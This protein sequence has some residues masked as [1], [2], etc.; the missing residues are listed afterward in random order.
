MSP[1]FQ[2]WTDVRTRSEAA[3]KKRKKWFRT[4]VRQRFFIILLLVLQLSAIIFFLANRSHASVVI[5]HMLQV[6]SFFVALHIIAKRDKGA[7]KLTWV[8]TIL[9]FRCSAAVSICC[10]AI[11]PAP[12]SC[13]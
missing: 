9:I 3:V 8:F 6:L 11:R 2:K 13:G 1:P 7:Y 12:K 5:K 10:S 4:L